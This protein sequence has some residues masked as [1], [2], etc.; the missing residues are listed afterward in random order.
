MSDK[1]AVNHIKALHILADCGVLKLYRGIVTPN[2]RANGQPP[3]VTEQM[4][5]AERLS[6]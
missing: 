4:N 3:E 5:H 2:A 6:R 1:M